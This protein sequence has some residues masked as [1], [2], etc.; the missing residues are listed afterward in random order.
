VA[1]VEVVSPGHKSTRS[2]PE[3]FV[4]EAADFMEWRVQ[5]LIL[6]RLLPGRHDPQ[7]IHGVIWDSICDQEYGPPGEKPL[8]LAV[9]ESDLAIRASVESVVVGDTL[10]DMPLF[11]QPR[12]CISVPLEASYQTAWEAVPRRGRDVIAGQR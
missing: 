6:D 12:G 2:A 1:V 9:Y 10:P 11:L 8:T 3:Q 7:G 5:L 4:R